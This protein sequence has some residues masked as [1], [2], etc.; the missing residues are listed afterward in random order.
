MVS[1]I[2]YF[3]WNRTQKNDDP[4][5][6]AKTKNKVFGF[7]P[8][9]AWEHT[10][11]GNLNGVIYLVLEMAIMWRFTRY[12]SC[13]FTRH[14]NGHNIRIN[15]LSFTI[16]HDT[17]SLF[18]ATFKD[19][20]SRSLIFSCPTLLPLLGLKSISRDDDQVDGIFFSPHSIFGRAMAIRPK[21]F[22]ELAPLF[23]RGRDLTFCG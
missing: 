18:P 15:C 21:R 2:N 13:I 5:V 7:A 10:T 23:Q 16:V 1:N 14:H 6:G 22:G 12:K 4:I 20:K 8:T 9:I 11:Y 19:Y 17:T 3:C